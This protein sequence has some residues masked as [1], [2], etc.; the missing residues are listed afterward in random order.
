MDAMMVLLQSDPKTVA[1]VQAGR[2]EEFKK[3]L[4]EKT[5]L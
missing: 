4:K 3:Y 5:R 2:F 1:L